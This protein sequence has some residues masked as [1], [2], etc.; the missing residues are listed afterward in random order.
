MVN[1]E[2]TVLITGAT[3]DFG[4]AFAQ[5]FYDG[6][7]SLIL[8]GRNPE[9]LAALQEEF[10]GSQVLCFDITDMDAVAD[11][12]ADFPA[13]DVLVNNAGGAIG[14]DPADES[15]LSDWMGMIDSNVR[16]LVAV[17]HAF[18]PKMV[19]AGHGHIINIGSVA[20]NYCYPGGHVY[21]GC[22]AF[23][24][25]FSGALRADLIGKNVRV[26]NI[27]PGIAETQFSLVRFKGDAD[28]AAAV[29]ADTDAL[30][31]EDV[32]ES[33][34]WVAVQPPHVNV[35]RLEIMSTMQATGPLSVHRKGN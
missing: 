7:F 5:K 10:P 12:L 8:H 1:S 23:V 13:V 15:Q 20:G 29:Y 30:Q 17:T 18:L 21:N 2:K 31:A 26:T 33:V 22:K 4:K 27:E 14:Q 24:K 6:G 9:K 28:R 34:Y 35:S 32:A 19:E 11:A 25:Q 3:G 16:G